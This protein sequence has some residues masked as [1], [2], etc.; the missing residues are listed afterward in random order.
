MGFE[1]GSYGDLYLTAIANTDGFAVKGESL[2]LARA[3]TGTL[4]YR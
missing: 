1:Q 4:E 2:I 3:D